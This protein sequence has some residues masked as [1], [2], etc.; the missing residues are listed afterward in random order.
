M[1]TVPTS[2]GTEQGAVEADKRNAPVL[3]AAQ[4][5]QLVRL[6]CAS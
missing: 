2:S 5:A 3:D 1:L 4:V 6:G